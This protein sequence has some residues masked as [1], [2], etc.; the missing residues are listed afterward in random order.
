MRCPLAVAELQACHRDCP[1]ATGWALCDSNRREDSPTTTCPSLEDTCRA[2]EA[3][4]HWGSERSPWVQARC[5]AGPSARPLTGTAITLPGL[6]DH[7]GSEAGLLGG[8]SGPSLMVE[9]SH[10]RGARARVNEGPLSS[11]HVNRARR[12]TRQ[13]PGSHGL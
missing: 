5:T 9:Q 10:H 4:A 11:A 2:E 8:G 12:M 7:E 6:A 1:T 13:S 3:T